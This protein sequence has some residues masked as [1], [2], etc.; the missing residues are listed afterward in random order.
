MRRENTQRQEVKQN[1]T[2]EKKNLQSR[3]ETDQPIPQTMMVQLNIVIYIALFSFFMLFY[4]KLNYWS[5]PV[6]VT[7]RPKTSISLRNAVLLKTSQSPWFLGTHSWT[8]ILTLS[9]F[10]FSTT[11]LSPHLGKSVFCHLPW[12]ICCFNTEA[13][14]SKC[15]FWHN[16]KWCYLKNEKSCRYETAK[17]K[18]Q[19]NNM[20]EAGACGLSAQIK[21]NLMTWS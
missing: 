18:L 19:P 6:F 9:Y 1:V 11:R 21:M 15:G 5:R 14:T 8:N 3:A 4:C 13:P 10:P 12:N 17:L 2:Q 7:W 16:L 20:F